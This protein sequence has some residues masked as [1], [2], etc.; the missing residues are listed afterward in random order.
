M[1]QRIKNNRGFGIFKAFKNN[2]AFSLLEILIASGILVVVIISLMGIFII[3]LNCMAQAKEINIATED[4]KDVLEKIKS[5]PFAQ[6]TD[7]T[8]FPDGGNVS[9]NVIGGFLLSDEN[10]VVNYPSGTNVDP[11]EIEAVIT[12]TGKDRRAYSRTFKTMRTSRL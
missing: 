6:L 11:L 4:L 7:P 8:K 12:W 1:R 9:A 5:T 3:S 10:I 2:N